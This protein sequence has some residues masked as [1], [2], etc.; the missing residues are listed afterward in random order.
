[1]AE[2]KASFVVIQ[3]RDIMYLDITDTVRARNHVFLRIFPTYSAPPLCIILKPRH[4]IPD[5][6]GLETIVGAFRKGLWSLGVKENR[7]A[8]K[9]ALTMLKRDPF[10]LLRYESP[11]EHY[12]REPSEVF[13]PHKDKETIVMRNLLTGLM[14]Q[15]Q[16]DIHFTRLYI[17]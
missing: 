11:P 5:D 2:S 3:G 7:L 16:Q 9:F 6:E 14:I 8:D 15:G 1:M 13:K 4:I 12:P 10:R 17:T